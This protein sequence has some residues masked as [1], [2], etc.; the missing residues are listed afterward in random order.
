M[1]TFGTADNMERQVN[2]LRRNSNTAPIPITKTKVNQNRV[3][4]MSSSN[5]YPGYQSSLNAILSQTTGSLTGD[6]D[7]INKRYTD[8]RNQVVA[9][10]G[11]TNNQSLLNARDLA[12]TEFDRQADD[13]TR[14]VSANYDAAQNKQAEFAA[15][16][17]ALGEEI[18]R[19]NA[20]LAAVNAGNMAAWN[21][22]FGV[23]DGASVDAARVAAAEAPRAQALAQA[24]G[25]SAAGFENAM[26]TSIGE[27]KTAIQG[28]IA[29]DLAARAG[30]VSTQTARDMAAAEMRDREMERQAFLDL[31]MRQMADSSTAQNNASE[32]SFA[33]QQAIAQAGLQ[34]G[35]FNVEEGRYQTE[36]AR[37]QRQDQI[38]QQRYADQIARQMEMDA[39]DQA[40][41]AIE[42]DWNRRRMAIQESEAGIGR[43]TYTSLDRGSQVQVGKLLNGEGS[44]D[45]TRI[46]G[47]ELYSL[48]LQAKNA[49]DPGLA[50][51][52]INSWWAKNSGKD[53]A[54]KLLE[55]NGHSPLSLYQSLGY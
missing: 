50:L 37:Q 41:Q 54:A 43:P 39:R 16:Q 38:E 8:L 22:Q 30:A 47:N 23:S 13:A 17:R 9:M 52:A 55:K 7:A 42:N 32:R 34:G 36:Q 28:Q 44:N 12:L 1:Q 27:Q 18:G 48:M 2:R 46:A 45:K 5:P 11:N 24:L 3:A 25:L 6:L 4:A 51:Q 19:Q 10:Y 49:N 31:V 29:R 15:R 20:A 14:Q 26:G 40:Q 35:L 53:G 33:L 21:D